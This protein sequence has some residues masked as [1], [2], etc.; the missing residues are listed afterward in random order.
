M[1]DMAAA[2]TRFKLIIRVDLNLEKKETEHNFNQMS[3]RLAQS[4][5]IHILRN[6]IRTCSASQKVKNV[7]NTGMPIIRADPKA[8]SVR[9]REQYNEWASSR[10]AIIKSSGAMVT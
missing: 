3:F 6:P 1:D 2:K 7:D 9:P 5:N 10:R 8:D 4:C